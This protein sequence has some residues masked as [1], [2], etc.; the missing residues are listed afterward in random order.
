MPAAASTPTEAIPTLRDP[1]SPP[2]ATMVVSEVRST[3]VM[4]AR[5]P[6]PSKSPAWWR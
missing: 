2:N 5:S 1:A 4:V 3:P 6:G